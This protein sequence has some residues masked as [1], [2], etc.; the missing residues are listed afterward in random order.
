M[1]ESE[2]FRANKILKANKRKRRGTTGICL[3]CDT[4]ENTT[5]FER[6]KVI[7]EFDAKTHQFNKP[8]KKPVIYIRCMHCGSVEPFE[9]R[10]E[11]K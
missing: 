2:M 4:C 5:D 10:E 9:T 1:K 3:F 7:G 6:L 11:A 8:M